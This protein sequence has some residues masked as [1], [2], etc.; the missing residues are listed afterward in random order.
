MATS[1]ADPTSP[2]SE[3]E[4]T[5]QP[6]G[7]EGGTASA[8]DGSASLSVPPGALPDTVE[9]TVS[10]AEVT[11][12]K[13][14]P[15]FGDIA[16]WCELPTL[17]ADESVPA[18]PVRLVPQ[19]AGTTVTV[20]ATAV[21]AV[22]DTDQSA[23]NDAEQL[24]IV[25]VDEG[26]IVDLKAGQPRLSSDSDPRVGGLMGFVGRVDN[27]GPGGS[28]GGTM[29]LEA[30]GD[31]ELGDVPG[32]CTVMEVTE[33]VAA[34]IECPVDPLEPFGIDAVGP[35]RLTALSAGQVTVE[36]TVTPAPEDTDVDP[37][38]DVN[39]L[40]VE[41]ASTFLVDLEPVSPGDLDG[42]RLP[43]ST[44]T[45][46]VRVG[47][48]RPPSHGGTVVYE[49]Q[50]DVA[51]GEVAEGCTESPNPSGVSVTCPFDAFVGYV[52]DTRGPDGETIYG[53]VGPF[54]L[55]PGSSGVITLAATTVPIDGDTDVN[56]D[57]DRY[58]RQVEIAEPAATSAAPEPGG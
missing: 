16:V 58:E 48:Y 30:T 18:P 52:N 15:S 1:C 45:F 4:P 55:V 53:W 12:E 23:E 5:P 8:S 11:A 6:I 38:N 49:A 37:E 26:A 51:L 20:R 2:P 17:R 32:T 13:P 50:G 19:E 36:A 3:S 43:G 47:N 21:A 35:L 29:L 39:R 25:V 33:P 22:E 9:I 31:V 24:A 44:L 42:A 14:D 57:N 54:Q 28:S 56:P 27:L 41:V 10:A 40:T 46:Q 7:P 34:A